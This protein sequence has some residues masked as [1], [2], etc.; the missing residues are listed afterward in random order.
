VAKNL[1]MQGS[2]VAMISISS[3]PTLNAASGSTEAR[4]DSDFRSHRW[5]FK[6]AM[7]ALCAVGVMVILFSVWRSSLSG[8]LPTE[9]RSGLL[10]EVGCLQPLVTGN[11]AVCL[12]WIWL[13][14]AAL[15]HCCQNSEARG[16]L[17][18]MMLFVIVAS[19]VFCLCTAGTKVDDV[20]VAIAVF[21][22]LPV[23]VVAVPLLWLAVGRMASLRLRALVLAGF[24]AASAFVQECATVAPGAGDETNIF[25]V[26]SYLIGLAVALWLLSWTTKSCTGRAA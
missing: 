3:E 9:Q 15:H 5:F 13:D 18:F 1:V 11:L 16:S 14:R 17:F 7:A 4:A 20:A 2:N 22:S 23:L 19:T 24:A 12:L 25:V 8:A 10:A 26:N 21:I 6:V